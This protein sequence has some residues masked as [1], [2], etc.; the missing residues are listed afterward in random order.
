MIKTAIREA[1]EEIGR[2]SLW[3]AGEGYDSIDVHCEDIFTGF[4]REDECLSIKTDWKP[5]W[6]GKELQDAVEF[7]R[8]TPKRLKSL[9]KVHFVILDKEQY[10]AHKTLTVCKILDGD[11]DVQS[12]SVGGSMVT[13]FLENHNRDTWQEDVRCWQD[14]GV[15][16]MRLTCAA[17]NNCKGNAVRR[18]LRTHACPFASASTRQLAF[19][20]L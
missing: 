12:L 2:D 19:P 10:E 14:R 8:N 16:R 15:G 5:P 7:V 6:A 1:F 11:G 18:A 9:N 4:R 20:S 3:L 17:S 13:S